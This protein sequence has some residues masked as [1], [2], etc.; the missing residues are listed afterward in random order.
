MA[1]E[2][3]KY[4]VQLASA[5]LGVAVG[6]FAAVGIGAAADDPSEEQILNALRPKKVTRSMSVNP[7]DAA[8]NAENERFIDAVRTKRTRSLS[9]GEREKVATIAAEKPTIDLEIKFD[10]NSAKIGP[11]AVPAVTKLGKALTSSDLNGGV[12]LVAG[13]TDAKG[14]EAYNQELS[15]KRAEAVKKYLVENFSVK[16]DHLVAVGYGKTR[17]KDKEHPTSEEN[18]RVQ[19]SNMK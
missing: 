12:F 8:R 4:R 1:R 19:V 16:P 6:L 15:D 14:G 13:H 3:T 9:M 10:Y 11:Q 7:E 18:R 5:A 2:Q 17:L